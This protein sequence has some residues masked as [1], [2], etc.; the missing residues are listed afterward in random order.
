MPAAGEL[1]GVPRPV[2]FAEPEPVEHRAHLRFDLDVDRLTVT[3]L[4][5]NGTVLILRD[6][7]RLKLRWNT[8]SFTR[9]GF[10]QYWAGFAAVVRPKEGGQS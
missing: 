7:T 10:L 9:P 4:S 5:L 3:D 8:R 6:G 2:F 1:L